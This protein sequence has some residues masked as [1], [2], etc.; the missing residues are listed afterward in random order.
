MN[1][2]DVQI[3]ASVTGR[4]PYPETVTGRG[5]LEPSIYFLQDNY[6][7][8]APKLRDA[9]FDDYRDVVKTGEAIGARQARDTANDLSTRP[10]ATAIPETVVFDLVTSANV[11]NTIQT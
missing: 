4:G 10:G 6:G 7:F 9:V 8:V 1:F 11:M 3:N 5:M 2:M